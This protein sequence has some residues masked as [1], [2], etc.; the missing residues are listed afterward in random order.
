MDSPIRRL[1]TCRQ[2]AQQYFDSIDQDDAAHL[3]IVCRLGD[4]RRTVPVSQTTCWTMIEAASCG[5]TAEREEFARIYLGPVQA[6]LTKRWRGT[7]FADVLD[8]AVQEVFAECFRKD[9]PLARADRSRGGFRPYL[10][11]VVRNVARAME[12]RQVARRERPAQSGVNLSKIAADDATLSAV[13]DRAWAQTIV[14]GAARLQ[15]ELAAKKG[16]DAERR[17]E[18]LH[19]RFYE[20]L[21]I[22]EIADRW[23]I[24]AAHL[25]REYA[26][27][28]EEFCQALC[29]IV[30]IHEPQTDVR[31][32]VEELVA[33]FGN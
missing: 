1:A 31:Q 10:Y 21:P 5:K 4:N 3:T 18:L 11:G 6:Y 19:L 12:R 32:R 20:N 33:A 23:Q 16:E 13:F 17:V 9:G 22:R 30:R 27:A 7:S 26:K 25:H 24:D 28:R 15:Q 8:D 29:E 2:A 14:R